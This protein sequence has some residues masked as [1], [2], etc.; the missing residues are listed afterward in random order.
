MVLK[1]LNFNYISTKPIHIA[2]VGNPNSGKSTLF[3]AITGLNQKVSNFPGTTVDYKWADVG[4]ARII[5]LPGTYSIYPKSGDE[6][7]TV[8]TILGQKTGFEPHKIV[9]VADASNLKR[10]LLLCLQVIDLGMP[11]VLALNMLDV[12][13]QKHIQIDSVELSKLLGIPVVEINARKRQGIDLLEKTVA[14][15][16]S[17]SKI[18]YQINPAIV[19]FLEELKIVIN[20]GNMY[21]DLVLAH[22]VSVASHSKQNIARVFSK[23]EFETGKLQARETVDRFKQIDEILIECITKTAHVTDRSNFA[24]KFITHKVWGLLIFFAL[25]FVMFQS[26][27]WLARW[28]MELIEQGFISLSSYTLQQLPNS[29]L[30]DLLANGVLS[31][32]SGVLV[33]VPQIVILFS[34]LT[35]LEDSGYMARVSFIMDRL[36]RSFGLNGKSVVPLI[37]GMACAVPSIMATRNIENVRDRLITIMVIPLMSCSARLPVYVLLIGLIVPDTQVWGILSMQGLVMLGMYLVGFV[38]ALLVAWVFKMVLKQ[39]KKNYFILEMPAYKW[40]TINNVSLV[41]WSRVKIFVKEAGLIILCVS[42]LLWFLGSYGPGDT[43]EKIENKYR[44]AIYKD[45]I[46]APS[47]MQAEKLEASYAGHFGKWIEPAIS[48][49]GF[50]WKIGIALLSSFAARE[51]FVGT[52]SAIYSIGDGEGHLSL[53]HKMQAEINI[54]TGKPRYSMATVWSLMFFYAFALQCTSTIAVVYRETKSW[55]WPLLQIV[56]LTGMAYLASLTIYQLF[57]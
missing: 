45:S 42:V 41:V 38:A 29:M 51:V 4:N 10:S 39:N 16:K 56:I 15:L 7:V 9:V 1:K 47:Q 57:S 22:Q 50:D 25:L 32:I 6:Q 2:L 21:K 20:T 34:L 44:Q 11:T 31:G 26:I 13:A 18:F 46:N 37:G 3:N 53:K 49:L 33:F 27:F 14:N 54:Q 40:P 28:P 23:Y 12:A 30:G 43:F 8:S 19:E 52:M 36:M 17:P 35:L 48:P 5:D 55:K 24:D